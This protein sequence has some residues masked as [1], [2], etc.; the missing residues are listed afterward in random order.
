MS[1]AFRTANWSRLKRQTSSD[2]LHYQGRLPRIVMKK[3]L[4]GLNVLD[5]SSSATGMLQTKALAE[6]GATVVWVESRA[7]LSLPRTSAPFSDGI[8]NEN[9]AGLV[10]QY[11]GPTYSMGLNVAHPQASELKRKLASWADIIVDGQR[12]GVMKNWGLDYES[13]TRFNPGVIMLSVSLEG[14]TGPRSKAP[15]WGIGTKGLQGLVYFTGWPDRPG[16]GT[17]TTYPDM[18]TP[19]LS[20]AILLA[21][22]DYRRRTG[23]GQYIDMSQFETALHF[24]PSFQMLDYFVNGRPGKAQG[25]RSP[26]AAPHGVFQCRGDDRWCA[27]AVST[28]KEWQALCRVMGDPA[29]TSESRFATLTGRKQ[30]EDEL[31]RLVGEWTVNFTAEEVMARLQASG[32]P[33]GVVQNSE[34]LLDKDPQIK[35]RHFYQKMS[36]PLME[37]KYHTGWPFI[38]SE[39]PYELRPSPLV[40]EHTEFVCRELLAMTDSQVAE[41]VAAGVL[42]LAAL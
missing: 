34:D 5:F 22:L 9:R 15:G 24:I 30:H 16:A 40:G 19:F 13:V 35:H 17:S 29:W 1:L 27:I 26:Y 7:H 21:A 2:I 38:L 8:V 28:D 6:H 3:A 33:S 14:Q 37:N 32:V 18:A 36:R 20:V 4:E 12:P 11:G 31:E 42:E 39:T 41:L 25:N 10:I 23:K